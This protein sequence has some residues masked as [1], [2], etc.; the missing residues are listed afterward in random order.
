MIRTTATGIAIDIQVVPRAKRS[1][2]S[3]QRDGRLLIR[4]AAPP[5]DGAANDALQAF[6]AEA[7]GCARRAVRIISGKKSRVKR[8]AIEGVSGETAA[9]TIAAASGPAAEESAAPSSRVRRQSRK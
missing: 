6:L 3:G 4:L 7:F 2:F 8:V 1:A 9:R 5:V